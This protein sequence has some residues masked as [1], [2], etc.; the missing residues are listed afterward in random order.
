MNFPLL[1][2]IFSCQ[3]NIP[4][5]LSNFWLANEI[6]KAAPLGTAPTFQYQ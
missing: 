4:V 2:T 3:T 6:K 1:Y 5:F